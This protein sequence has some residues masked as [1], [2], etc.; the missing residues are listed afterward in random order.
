MAGAV[1]QYEFCQ[2]RRRQEREKMKRVVEVYDRKQG[3]MRAMEEA[4]RRRREQEEER[5]GEREKERARRRWYKF[6]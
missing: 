1:A 6:W 4:E 2:W 3:E 5:E